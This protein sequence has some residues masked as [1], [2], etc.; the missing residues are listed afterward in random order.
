MKHPRHGEVSEAFLLCGIHC[1]FYEDR[2]LR[3]FY[4][5]DRK[6]IVAQGTQVRAMLVAPWP[7]Q[8][9]DH[10]KNGCLD[11]FVSEVKSPIGVS[12]LGG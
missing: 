1:V 7:C 2:V 8:K 3:N 11:F 5:W 10:T 6:L 4:V 12:G 9:H